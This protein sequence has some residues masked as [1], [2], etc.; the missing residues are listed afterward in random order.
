[1]RHPSRRFAIVVALLCAA[2]LAPLAHAALSGGYSGKTSHNRPVTFKVRDG[3]VK[4]FEAGINLYCFVFGES[5]TYQFDAVIPPKA[6][7]IKPSGRFDYEGKDAPGTGNIKIHGKFV[8]KRKATG[9]IEMG[10]G[11]CAGEATFS[12]TKR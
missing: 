11:S 7:A 3:K 10:T 1:M 6:L 9:R 12:A 8:T 5:G 4:N 2:L